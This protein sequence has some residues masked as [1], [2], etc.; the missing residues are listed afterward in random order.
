[1]RRNTPEPPTNPPEPKHQHEHEFFDEDEEMI[2]EDGAV[3]FHKKCAYFDGPPGNEWS[4][5]ETKTKR[6]D[7]VSMTKLRSDKP[8]IK[9][10]AGEADHQNTWSHVERIFEENLIEVETGGFEEIDHVLPTEF[11]ALIVE[12]ELGKYL[13][14]YENE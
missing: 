4:C 3:I 8:V 13:L 11:V 2:V 9:W 5:E 7:L 1:M 6:F 10:L 14:T 12:T